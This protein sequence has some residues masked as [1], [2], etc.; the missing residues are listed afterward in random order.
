LSNLEVGIVGLPNVGKS[1]LFNAITKAGAEAANFPFCT[2]EPNV[3]VVAVPDERLNVLHKM[4][5]SKKTTPASV[6]FVDIA[7]LVK[8][9]ANGEGLGN[10]FLE[11]IR[12]VDAV[13]HVVRCFDDANITHVEGGVDPLRDIDI[14]QTELCLADLEV[15]EKRIMRLAKIAKSGNKEA[16]VEDEILR[17]IKESLDNGKPARQVE[18]TADE[19]E[20]I[21]DINLLTLKPTLY[22]TN[23]AEDEVATAYEENAY[24]QKVKEFAKAE[25]AEVVAISARVEAEIAE[26]DAEEA[27]AF[28][29]DLGETESGLDRL[30]KAAFDL[31]GLQTF[32]TAGPDECRA[33]T[34][35]KGTTAPKAAGKIH[36]DFERG[37]IR[38]EIVNYDDLVANGSVAAAREKGQVRVEGKDYVMQDGGV[39]NFRFNV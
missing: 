33:W 15:V 5:D 24:V 37:F 3:G 23:V 21:K 9:A 31:L 10:K 30:I 18:L 8:G 26:L 22:V 2:I 36:T 14:I 13:A 32:L 16:K 25:N 7:G 4:Y 34:I 38:A 28:L 11:H 39:V 6:R 29:E 35:T 12:Q 20:M 17:R 27:K 19:L 1:T